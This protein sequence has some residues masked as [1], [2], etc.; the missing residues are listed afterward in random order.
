MKIRIAPVEVAPPDPCG[1]AFRLDF[2]TETNTRNDT[3]VTIEIVEPENSG[4]FFSGFVWALGRRAY[5][6]SWTRA[7]RANDLSRGFD[8]DPKASDV[9]A[10]LAACADAAG[11]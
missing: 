9:L 11:A 10:I 4:R 7:G 3:L 1:P 6:A 5:P 2:P 8:I